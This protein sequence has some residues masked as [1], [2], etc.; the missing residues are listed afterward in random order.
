M[1]SVQIPTTFYRLPFNLT[2]S[3]F[4]IMLPQIVFL[5]RYN[6]AGTHQTERLTTK[7]QNKKNSPFPFSIKLTVWD[8]LSPSFNISVI[9]HLVTSQHPF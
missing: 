5:K 4:I 3:F 7:A 1:L 8:T 6:S 2:L 9:D